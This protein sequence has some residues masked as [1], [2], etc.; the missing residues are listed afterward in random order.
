MHIDI[1][2]RKT[3]YEKCILCGKVTYVKVTLSIEERKYYIEGIGQLCK[4]CYMIIDR[5]N[6]VN[7]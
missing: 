1:D 6:V 7:Q 5:K 3:E 2:Y 4:K